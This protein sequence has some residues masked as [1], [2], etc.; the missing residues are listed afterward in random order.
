[1]RYQQAMSSS[2]SDYNI[3]HGQRRRNH[4]KDIKISDDNYFGR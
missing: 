2:S 4:H 1:M 3:N